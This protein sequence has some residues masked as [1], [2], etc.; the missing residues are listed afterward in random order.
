MSKRTRELDAALER[1]AATRQILQVINRS[2]DDYEPVFDAILESGTRLCGAQCGLLLLRESDGFHIVA[3]RGTRPEVAAYY[4]AHPVPLDPER[5][6][7]ARTVAERRPLQ[8]LDAADDAVY[9]AGMEHR[10]LA[11]E[12]DGLRSQLTVPLV[13]DDEGIGVILI[14]RREVRA[15]DDAQVALLSGFA[16]MAVIALEN[17]R[18]F[19]ALNESLERQTAT[20]EILRTISRS[21]TDYQPVFDT[22]LE[23]ATR[24]CDAPL[25][26]LYLVGDGGIHPVANRGTRKEFLDFLRDNVRPAR[27]EAGAIGRALGGRRSVQVHD[28]AREDLYRG[29]DKWRVAAVELEGIRTL[30]TVPLLKGE[31]AI[32]VIVL[33]RREVRPF[34][35]RHVNLVETFADQAVIAIENVRQ[36]QAVQERTEALS[37]S[38]A[39][40]TA[41]SE[42]LRSISRSPTDYVPVFQTILENATRLC[43]ARTGVLYLLRDGHLHLAA[44]RGTRPELLE[45]LK[46][47]PLPLDWEDGVVPRAARERIPH[48]RTK[49][50]EQVYG[51]RDGIRQNTVALGGLRTLLAVPLL[52]GSEAIGV[53][54]FSRREANPFPPEDIEL[55]RSFA[56]QAV[57]AIENV[58]LFQALEERNAALNASL[59]RQTA[60]SEILRTIS[61]SPTDYAPV[62]DTILDNATR[63][64]DAPLAFL[65]I[66][67]GDAFH[68]VANRGSRP[69]FAY[70]SPSAEYTMYRREFRSRARPHATSA[71]RISSTSSAQTRCPWT[72]RGRLQA[73]PRAAGCHS[74]SRTSSTARAIARATF[75]ASPRPTWR[76]SG[77]GCSCR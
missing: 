2:P 68:F 64:C 29:G 9:H 32:G 33:Y 39:R 3:H 5:T 18:R 49:V 28:I 60:T 34:E 63:L 13:R 72:R 51:D 11:V 47:N 12:F 41:T 67:E 70:S 40:Q 56:D 24:L 35:A 21:P 55:V 27:R 15:F 69:E 61:R 19:R 20:S 59:E 7:A 44:D 43:R 37:E 62:F 57:I 65:L 46:A 77:P 45:Y 50:D 53:L 25:A 76:A 30:V 14:Y 48:Q 71:L 17:V 4:H 36:F 42:I 38:L 8:V 16:E 52:K 26:Q 23:N 58:R 54:A 73:W 22:I 75:T 6:V 31:E 1:E 66:R 74:S 10:R